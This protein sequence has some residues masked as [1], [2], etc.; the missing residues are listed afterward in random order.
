[1]CMWQKIDLANNLLCSTGRILA[2]LKPLSLGAASQVGY[3]KR[4]HCSEGWSSTHW[5]VSS[6]LDRGLS[7]CL[8]FTICLTRLL[9]LHPVMQP[10]SRC[11]LAKST[12][13]T[14]CPDFIGSGEL[15]FARYVYPGWLGFGIHQYGFV[16]QSLFLVC[17]GVHMLLIFF[18]VLLLSSSSF[19]LF[20]I[21]I[22]ALKFVYGK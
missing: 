13:R 17:A 8:T 2:I 7:L 21:F 3:V 18:V 15:R 10:M 4:L 16:F 12:E 1:M 11:L 20:E 6:L 14:G 5:L 19:S 9:L 22:V